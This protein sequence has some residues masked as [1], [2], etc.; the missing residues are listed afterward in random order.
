MVLLL[1]QLPIDVPGKAVKHG[2][3][4]WYPATNMEDLD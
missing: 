4:V 2:I 1:I 3:R